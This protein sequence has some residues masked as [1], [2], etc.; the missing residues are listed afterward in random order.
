MYPLRALSFMRSCMLISLAQGALVAPVSAVIHILATGASMKEA[1]NFVRMVS[2][3]W[4][5]AH[6]VSQLALS[7]FPNSLM[8]A[9]GPSTWVIIGYFRVLMWSA[10][11]AT[12]TDV[13]KALLL[14]WIWP[15]LRSPGK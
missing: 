13:L 8:W 11:P 3:V 6:L 10:S 12:W 15:A 9:I 4:L 14:I 1:I 2:L 7:R 5:T